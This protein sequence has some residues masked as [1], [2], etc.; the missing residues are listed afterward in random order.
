VTEDL[1]EVEASVHRKLVGVLR[2]EVRLDGDDFGIA[3][4]LSAG[5][6][7]ARVPTGL[8]DAPETGL[9]A[10]SGGVPVVAKASW[11]WSTMRA[12]SLW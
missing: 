3:D 1:G 9:S 12:W 2:T 6:G 8:R 7:R 10:G 11:W 5:D 4:A